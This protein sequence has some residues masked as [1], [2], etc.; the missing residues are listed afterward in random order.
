MIAVVSLVFIAFTL[1]Y[2]FFA[3]AIIYHLSAYTLPGWTMGRVSIILFV[4]LSIVLYALA[5]YFF[6]QI[7]W[8]TYAGT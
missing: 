5:I 7:P 4:V 2:F 6:L 8:N 1:V 3:G